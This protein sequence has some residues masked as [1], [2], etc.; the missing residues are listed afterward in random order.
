MSEITSL[1]NGD[2][3]GDP[4]ASEQLLSLVYEE[5]RLLGYRA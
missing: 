4:H 2:D 3:A 5:L 1:L